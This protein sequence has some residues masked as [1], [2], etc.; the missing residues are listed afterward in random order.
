MGGFLKGFN[1]LRR[2]NVVNIFQKRLLFL[3]LHFIHLQRFIASL[4]PR[5]SIKLTFKIKIYLHEI[6]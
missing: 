2:T 3:P 6:H 5:Y 4:R 1:R